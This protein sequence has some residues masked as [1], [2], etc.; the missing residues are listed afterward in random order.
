M[1]YRSFLGAELFEVGYFTNSEVHHAIVRIGEN[2]DPARTY[3]LVCSFQPIVIGPPFTL[4]FS[5]C[6]LEVEQGSGAEYRWWDGRETR[7]VVVPKQERERCVN[8][9]LT[10]L[11]TLLAEVRP[12][13]IFMQTCSGDLPD[14]AMVKY[15]RVLETFGQL[16]YSITEAPE[17]HGRRSWW[18]ERIDA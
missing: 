10:C 9:I 15:R 17:Y 3:S 1:A 11:E 16:G 7:G 6:L 14:R 4:E 18:M 13:D 2:D 5:F 12:K 8:V